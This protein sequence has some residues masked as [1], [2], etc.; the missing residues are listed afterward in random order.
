MVI[1]GLE[2]GIIQSNDATD[3]AIMAKPLMRT[4]RNL[5]IK[6]PKNNEK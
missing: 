2:K 6:Y 3:P 4:K 1:T 5:Y